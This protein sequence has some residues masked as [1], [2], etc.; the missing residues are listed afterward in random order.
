MWLTS[1]D[2][3][4]FLSVQGGEKHHHRLFTTRETL[5]TTDVSVCR[6]SFKYV[7]FIIFSYA[8]LLLKLNQKK[9]QK[10]IY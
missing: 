1:R 9:P 8:A 5:F 10:K 7:L 2:S 3:F 4:N 6:K